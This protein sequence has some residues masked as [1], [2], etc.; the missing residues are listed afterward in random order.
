MGVRLQG[1][2]L[3]PGPHLVDG[4]SSSRRS[5]D[6]RENPEAG[7]QSSHMTT[8]VLPSWRTEEVMR[9]IVIGSVVAE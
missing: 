8:G 9:Q 3:P 6:H 1:R 5:H 2:R 4:P 7:I